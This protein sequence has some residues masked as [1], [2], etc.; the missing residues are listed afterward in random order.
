MIGI[1]SRRSMELFDHI[2]YLDMVWD[3][4]SSNLDE[5]AERYDD[6][7]HMTIRI[8]RFIEQN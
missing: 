1:E 6:L 8:L 5:L 2:L 3:Y 7:E 4:F